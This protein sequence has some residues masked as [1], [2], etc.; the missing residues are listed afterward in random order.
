MN[1]SIDGLPATIYIDRDGS[2]GEQVRLPRDRSRFDREDV[3]SRCHQLNSMPPPPHQ[4]QRSIY[5]HRHRPSRRSPSPEERSIGNVRLMNCFDAPPPRTIFGRKNSTHWDTFKKKYSSPSF[6]DKKN[7]YNNQHT[8][9][10]KMPWENHST[11]Q[12]RGAKRR[13]Q[14]NQKKLPSVL[15][16]FF[17]PR[18]LPRRN[19]RRNREPEGRTHGLDEDDFNDDEVRRTKRSPLLERYSKYFERRSAR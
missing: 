15:L 19:R 16:G 9:F 2:K 12:Q 8:F 1:G 13:N 14:T 4:Q 6:P 7:L 11:K 10:E 3:V 5:D 18:S 17:F